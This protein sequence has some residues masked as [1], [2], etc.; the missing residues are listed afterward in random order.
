MQVRCLTIAGGDIA[1]LNNQVLLNLHVH[2]FSLGE[3]PPVYL[4]VWNVWFLSVAT[5]SKASSSW[6]PALQN[7]PHIVVL[8]W[9]MQSHM[10]VV[11][12]PHHALLGGQILSD[13]GVVVHN[14]NTA[15]QSEVSLGPLMKGSWLEGHPAWCDSSR[16]A[17]PSGRGL[18]YGTIWL[19][20][21]AYICVYSRPF[22][23]HCG[24]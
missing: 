22:L 15:S 20:M 2:K 23:S 13:G 5:T 11:L 14:R 4:S 1:S 6:Q 19:E 21:E 16:T 24:A 12:F 3:S 7:M 9:S 18:H 10:F 8:T 17:V